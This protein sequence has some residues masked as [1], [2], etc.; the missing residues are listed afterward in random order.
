MIVLEVVELH[1]PIPK[2]NLSNVYNM[3]I[4]RL[5]RICICKK[6]Q[7]TSKALNALP[8]NSR[9]TA[10]ALSGESNFIM[11]MYLSCFPCSLPDV[12]ERLHEKGKK[13]TVLF[14]GVRY[15]TDMLLGSVTTE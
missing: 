9:Y 5:K 2:F 7:Q 1:S 3:A 8:F 13:R 4:I 6:E 11:A 15:Y 14:V 10:S 12:K